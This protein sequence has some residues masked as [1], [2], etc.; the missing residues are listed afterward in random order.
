MYNYLFY[1]IFFNHFCRISKIINNCTVFLLYL[2]T[3]Y[4]NSHNSGNAADSLASVYDDTDVY[5][6]APSS[7]NVVS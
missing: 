2:S 7:I 1:F 6:A 4:D 3:I 5:V